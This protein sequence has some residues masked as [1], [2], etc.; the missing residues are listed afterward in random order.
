M[1]NETCIAIA[2]AVGALLALSSAS[3]PAAPTLHH[4]ERPIYKYVK[5]YGV[6]RAGRN[7]CFTSGSACAGS[8]RQ[9]GQH[10]AWIY[11]PAGTC[12][13]ITGGGLDPG[14]R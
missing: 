13:K 1:K 11:L 7:D 6:A 8:T 14:R 3:A 4:P 5:C 2:S 9:D 10:D 12:A